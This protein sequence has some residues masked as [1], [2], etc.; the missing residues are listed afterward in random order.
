MGLLG[1]ISQINFSVSRQYPILQQVQDERKRG[2]WFQDERMGRPP[3]N[4]P[5]R[6]SGNPDGTENTRPLRPNRRR[7]PAYAGMTVGGRQRPFYTDKIS[8]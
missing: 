6:V 4:R 7:I 8:C 1:V 3:R 2:N 5:S